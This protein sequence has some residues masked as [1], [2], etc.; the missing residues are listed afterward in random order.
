M[1]IVVFQGVKAEGPED[2]LEISLESLLNDKVAQKSV[3]EC[4]DGPQLE[5]D[6]VTFVS[7]ATG[8]PKKGFSFVQITFS[9]SENA[10]CNAFSYQALETSVPC[11]LSNCI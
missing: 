6:L 11:Q 5:T 4:L 8:I 9:G 2:G 10:T 7:I 3:G 1:Q